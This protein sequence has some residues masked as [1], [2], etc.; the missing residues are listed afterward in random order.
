MFPDSAP[1]ADS[2][3]EMWKRLCDLPEVKKLPATAALAVRTLNPPPDNS[4]SSHLI[5]PQ[6]KSPSSAALPAP[7]IA[8]SAAVVALRPTRSIPKKDSASAPGATPTFNAVM[9]RSTGPVDTPQPLNSSSDFSSSTL[10]TG[11][12]RRSRIS[13]ATFRPCLRTISEGSARRVSVLWSRQTNPMEHSPSKLATDEFSDPLKGLELFPD[14]HVGDKT[15]SGSTVPCK[16]GCPILTEGSTD[17][18]TTVS[19]QSKSRMQPEKST[20]TKRQPDRLFFKN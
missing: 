18:F 6:R 14:L 13:S 4:E 17:S 2:R 20:P 10:M 15:R 3:T 9:A 5:A 7:P 11:C 19:A 12:P 1:G 8:A 16:H